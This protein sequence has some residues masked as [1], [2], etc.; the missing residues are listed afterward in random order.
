MVVRVSDMSEVT[1]APA[2]LTFTPSAW[3]VPHVLVVSPLNDGRQDGDVTLTV[4][5]AYTSMD[6]EFNG[7]DEVGLP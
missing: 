5:L 6:T 1:V 2:W 3:A 4:T 7:S